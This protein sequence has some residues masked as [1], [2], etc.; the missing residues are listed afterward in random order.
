METDKSATA[1][2]NWLYGKEQIYQE[3]TRDRSTVPP[4]PKLCREFEDAGYTK[5]LED[6]LQIIFYGP[7]GTGKTW[8]A[9]KFAECRSQKKKCEI[10]MVTF[11]ASYSYEDFVEGFRPV[12]RNIATLLANQM[13]DEIK[14]PEGVTEE[15]KMKF[16]S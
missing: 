2:V 13:Y 1:L 11:H 14:L 10:K 7:P 9:E 12:D 15:R 8:T 4:D 16:R 3:T 6:M 5:L